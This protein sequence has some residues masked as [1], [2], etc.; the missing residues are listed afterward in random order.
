MVDVPRQANQRMRIAPGKFTTSTERFKADRHFFAQQ[1]K[2]CAIFFQDQSRCARSYK[3]KYIH[4]LQAGTWGGGGEG[5]SL[6]SG[7]KKINVE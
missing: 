7:R 3:T 2:F 1:P 6:A 5:G 4:I